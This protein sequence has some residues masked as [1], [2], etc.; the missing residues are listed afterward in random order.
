[1]DIKTFVAMFRRLQTA[2]GRGRN[3]LRPYRFHNRQHQV[4]VIWHNDMIQNF[5]VL[6]MKMYQVDTIFN[7]GTEIG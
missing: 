2:F 4:D 6:M 7:N 5:G 3:I 1:M